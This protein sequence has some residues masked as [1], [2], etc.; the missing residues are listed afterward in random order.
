MRP[1]RCS[2]GWV[3]W[4]WLIVWV[5][6]VN[7]RSHCGEVDNGGCCLG[8]D[9]KAVGGRGGITT[10]GVGCS[11][12]TFTS[13]ARVKIR[14]RTQ[15][16]L[17]T[18]LPRRVF[19]GKWG[20]GGI[21]GVSSRLSSFRPPKAN[22]E[23]FAGGSGGAGMERAQPVGERG[24]GSQTEEARPSWLMSKSTCSRLLALWFESS[25]HWFS[26]DQ[27]FD[28]KICAEFL[29]EI[30]SIPQSLLGTKAGSLEK[31][32]RSLPSDQLL[33]HVVL[34][35]QVS[36]HYRR[37]H[38]ALEVVDIASPYAVNC[39]RFLLQHRLNEVYR[40]PTSWQV[41]LLMPWRHLFSADAL[42]H[43]RQ[44]QRK[45]V[46]QRV[47]QGGL[48][49]EDEALWNRF[50]KATLKAQAKVAN[51]E[52]I[53]MVSLEAAGQKRE[54]TAV[55]AGASWESFR[56]ILEST[57]DIN[58]TLMAVNDRKT[59]D[60]KYVYELDTVKEV[61][62]FFKAQLEQPTDSGVRVLTVSVSG[63]V[64]SMALLFAAKC[65]LEKI[66]ATEQQPKPVLVAVHINYAN[67]ITADHEASFVEAWCRML[68]VPLF[69][70]RIS[71]VQRTRDKDRSFYEEITRE[72]RFD[73]YKAAIAETLRVTMRAHGGEGGGEEEAPITHEMIMQ[74]PVLL[75]HNRQDTWENLLSNVAKGQKYEQL[76]GMAEIGEEQDVVIWRPLLRVN[77]A[78]LYHDADYL[79]IPHL[80]DSTPK[81][82]DRGKMRDEVLPFLHANMPLLIPG[83]ERLSD[84][85]EFLSE[86]FRA[87]LEAYW[88][89]VEVNDEERTVSLPL[90][91]WIYSSKPMWPGIFKRLM[92]RW[93]LPLPS[94][95]SMDLMHDWL[96]R[97]RDGNIRGRIPSYELS[98]HYKVLYR[99]DRLEIIVRVQ[100]TNSS[101]RCGRFDGQWA[102]R[103]EHH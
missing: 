81:W 47:A 87:Q 84:H 65:A 82:C 88:G 71:E 89:T 14:G 91:P 6:L 53:L 80:W 13:R 78:Q 27:R 85:L 58:T 103:I 15:Q 70:R 52:S 99:K 55:G 8:A 54:R 56:P 33:A 95:K 51:R 31:E 68:D 35:D 63:G 21:S 19:P 11:R 50:E 40:W 93:S 48:S 102:G 39:T 25:R 75:G 17:S 57:P 44:W 7:W 43:V 12:P 67:R 32:F 36:R 38:S 92:E 59:Q 83:L 26:T 101:S 61:C 100:D 24:E 16:R 49:E 2:E 79:G 23:G 62:R 60:G 3:C 66:R 45:L 76:R 77:K 1:P 72:I 64:D 10:A 18:N 42:Q 96:I 86:S 28:E 4:R 30:S 90:N 41:F 94:H 22:L 69:T 73:V 5:F 98:K 34:W 74:N 97:A 29:P 20:L 46:K 37:L 9:A